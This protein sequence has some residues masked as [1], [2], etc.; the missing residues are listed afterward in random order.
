MFDSICIQIR[1]NIK[2]GLWC[3][4]MRRHIGFTHLFKLNQWDRTVL[5]P[6]NASQMPSCVYILETPLIFLRFHLLCF[7]FLD[8]V[9]Q[10]TQKD[11]PREL[12]KW[13]QTFWSV[14]SFFYLFS[15][16]KLTLIKVS[17]ISFSY[18]CL[19]SSRVL[20]C[21][22][23]RIIARKPNNVEFKIFDPSSSWRIFLGGRYHYKDLNHLQKHFNRLIKVLIFGYNSY[24]KQC[25][26]S[27]MCVP[28]MVH[29]VC[30]PSFTHHYAK[31]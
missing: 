23:S 24:Y 4:W 25:R 13:E 2:Q 22:Q 5:S 30:R 9:M 21:C 16:L 12:F 1:P 7:C 20:Q 29:N 8:S 18:N 6:V 14:T 31:A 3:K 19:K 26:S 10:H 17:E 11:L 27:G 15:S 28:I